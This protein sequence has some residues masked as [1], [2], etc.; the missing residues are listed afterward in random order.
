M[1][2]WSLEWNYKITYLLLLSLGIRILIFIFHYKSNP[3]FYVPLEGATYWEAG[4]DGYLQLAKT[5]LETGTF[6]F[7]PE[8][9]PTNSRPLLPSFLFALFVAWNSHSWHINLLVYNLILWFL[10]AIL[11]IKFIMNHIRPKWQMLTLTFLFF[12]PLFILLV[13]TYTFLPL[14]T[15]LYTCYF[16]TLYKVYHPNPKSP[17]KWHL[18]SSFIMSLLILTHRSLLL[19]PF[20]HIF[21]LI[22]MQQISFRKQINAMVP[23]ILP[24]ITILSLGLRNWSLY[25]KFFPIYSGAGIV[26]WMSEQNLYSIPDLEF[27]KYKELTGK[28]LNALYYTTLN[29]TDDEILFQAAIDTIIKDPFHFLDHFLK[30]LLLF[31]APS[32]QGTLKMVF[33]ICHNLLLWISIFWIYRKRKF[34]LYKYEL[35]FFGTLFFH[36]LLFGFFA[37]NTSY[38]TFFLPSL[39]LIL[40]KRLDEFTSFSND[41]ARAIKTSNFE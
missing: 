23:Y 8:L 41:N 15:L 40:F 28:E 33:F 18:L 24:L 35:A 14:A 13:R 20:I 7:S 12:H 39:F 16:F 3:S 11:F 21:F 29:P 27:I 5:F 30:G 17:L 25:H 6:A 1:T 2:F 10:M 26:Y 32:D 36:W 37:S 9:P 34:K 19:L 22:V 38:C 31:W 4:E